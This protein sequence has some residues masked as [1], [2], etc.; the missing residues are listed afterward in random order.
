MGRVL[1]LDDDQE[2]V[3]LLTGALAT[4]GHEVIGFSRPGEALKAFSQDPRRFDLVLTDMS[5]PAGS[6]L[7]FAQQILKI[8][9]DADII[10]ASGCEEP[11]WAD[12]ARACGVRQVIEKPGSVEALAR[13]IDSLLRGPAIAT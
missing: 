5:M 3:F 13:T 12:H 6:G 8:Y 1:Y 10:V 2:L 11:N 7:D 9:A 4:L